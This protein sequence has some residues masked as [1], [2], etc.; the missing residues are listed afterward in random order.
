M[1]FMSYWCDNKNLF[2]YRELYA[3]HKAKPAIPVLF[4]T[5]EY[6]MTVK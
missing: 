6:H 4:H 3:I 5:T 1:N 2:K